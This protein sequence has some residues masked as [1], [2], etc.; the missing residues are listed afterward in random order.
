MLGPPLIPGFP[1][2]IKKKKK[3]KNPQEP[4]YADPRVLILGLAW[5]LPP[6]P[7]LIKNKKKQ[8]NPQEP[9][10]AAQGTDSRSGLAS[11][12]FPDLN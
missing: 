11:A 2:F 1:T 4:H 7:T 10:Y 5:L 9:H 8:K 12:S 6:F 3:Q